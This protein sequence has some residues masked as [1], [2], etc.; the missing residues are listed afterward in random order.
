MTIIDEVKVRCQ[1][2]PAQLVKSPTDR[3][4]VCYYK[5]GTQYLD[6][7][8]RG[9]AEPGKDNYLYFQG[10]HVYDVII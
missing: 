8:C 4:A 6:Y 1:I 7:T 2:Y 3:D 9:Q 10:R 5:I